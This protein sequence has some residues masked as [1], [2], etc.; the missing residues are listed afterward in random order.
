MPHDHAHDHAREQAHDPAQG[1]G[2]H[3]EAPCGAREFGGDAGARA[4]GVGDPA[5]EAYGELAMA[6]LA[7][8]DGE[9]R[10]AATH[11]ANALFRVPELPEAHAMLEV[12]VDRAPDGGTG[13]FVP[14]ERGGMFAGGAAARAHLRAA[15]GEFDAAVG[16]LG[17]V[18]ASEPH[19]P[20]AA[21]APW[22]TPDLAP[23][24]DPD[25]F[26][27]TLIRTSQFLDDPVP[28]EH[29][30][31]FSPFAD[32]ARAMAEAHPGH[33]VLLWT[34]SSFLRRL[35]AL[36]EAA[37]WAFRA[38]TRDR[39]VEA[40]VMLGTV[41]RRTGREADTEK[42]WAGVLRD[43]PENLELH[44]DLGEL[45]AR[46]GRFDEG[47]G[48]IERALE[49]DPAHPKAAPAAHGVRWDRDRDTAHLVALIDHLRRHPDHGYAHEL[50]ARA[51]SGPWLRHAPYPTEALT[52][53]TR[54]MLEQVEPGDADLAVTLSALEPPSALLAVRS[55]FPRFGLTVRSVPEPDLRVPSRPG[56][57][58]VW[59]Y[60][61]GST[62]A[63]PVA[64]PPAPAVAAAVRELADPSW[65]HPA[66]A[67]DCAVRLA[68]CELADL[69]GVLVHPPAPDDSELGRAFARHE[70]ALWV[71][72]VQ[73]WAC[74]GI[75]HHRADEPWAGSERRRVLVDLAFGTEDW[76]SDAALFA[77][78]AT[79]WLVPDVRDDVAELVGERF[80]EA[81]RAHRTRE[82]TLLGSL[83]EL[84]LATPEMIPD[85]RELARTVLRNLADE[86]A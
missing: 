66:F 54:R 46:Q 60:D 30:A 20:W 16:D 57:Y 50:V 68:G 34:G 70:P 45:L 5:Q 58:A 39:S 19:R 35:D 75:A 61:P 69:L 56:G 43:H 80:V 18:A 10:H 25:A 63:R 44:V 36:R 53:V 14:D 4:E 27:R 37:D 77:M 29:R 71:R 48:W 41:W 84:A 42:L 67:Y 12:L 40:A 13:L 59:A 78:V 31:H 21:S 23:R 81:V 7:L 17:Q 3:G 65:A 11:V 22:L 82:V 47:L 24:L 49:A 8:D 9:L 51:C 38:W 62:E 79:A 64:G 52:N 76:V 15:A 28:E 55:A 73:I 1:P 72:T 33:G 2:G 85:V 32:V 26:A 6:R 74:L 86:S 83:A